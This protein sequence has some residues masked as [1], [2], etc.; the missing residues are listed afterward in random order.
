MFQDLLSIIQQV[1]VAVGTVA[2]VAVA[3][4][5]GKRMSRVLST[6]TRKT[7]WG[8]R[9]VIDLGAVRITIVVIVG[10]G[11]QEQPSLPGAPG[12]ERDQ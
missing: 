3:A 11:P 6:L 8:R 10:G 1:V 5:M 2:V 9:L 7:S 12:D 4:A